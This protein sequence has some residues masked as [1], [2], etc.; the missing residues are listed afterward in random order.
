MVWC[1]LCVW[2]FGQLQY[3]WLQRWGEIM[4]SNGLCVA[5]VTL[6]GFFLRCIHTTTLYA[7]L[8]RAV[9]AKN[10]QNLWCLFNFSTEKEW[11]LCCSLILIWLL[12]PVLMWTHF[13]F[14][15]IVVDIPSG[16]PLDL[17]FKFYRHPCLI[18]ASQNCIQK[19]IFNA[20]VISI[21]T[22][23]KPPATF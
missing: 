8:V 22:P 4:V 5:Y 6:Q 10:T 18:T 9:L 11:V 23:K 16:Y 19:I 17:I 21:Y 12:C 1:G 7:I 14:Y 2:S 13:F 20:G 15:K 3:E